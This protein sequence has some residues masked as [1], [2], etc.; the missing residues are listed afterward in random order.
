VLR[1]LTPQLQNLSRYRHSVYTATISNKVRYAEAPSGKTLIVPAKM[2]MMVDSSSNPE[3]A[4]MQ[5]KLP[6][7]IRQVLHIL[8]P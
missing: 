7:Y 2:Q 1:C 5:Q 3:P 8:T 4:K 6:I